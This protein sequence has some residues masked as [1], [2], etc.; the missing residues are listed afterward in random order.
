MAATLASVVA[1]VSF[2]APAAQ[3]GPAPVG[4]SPPNHVILDWTPPRTPAEIAVLQAQATTS[5]ATTIKTFTTTVVD[6]ASTFT[7]TMVGKNPFVAQTNPSKTIQATLIPVV[8]KFSNGD[9]WD[10]SAIDSC[11]T[12]SALTRTQ[13]SP[14]FQAQPWSFGAKSV[15]TGQYIDAF[16][17]A[18]FYKKTKP[19]GIN[20]GYAV[21][22]ALTTHAPFVLNV[23]AADSAELYATVCGNDKLGEVNVN[24][25]DAQLQTYIV[26]TLG[27]A[28]TTTFPLFV[29]GNV[30][31]YSGTPTN[32]CILG[33]HNAILNGGNLQ[34]YGISMYDNSGDFSPGGDT[35]TMAHEVGEWMNDPVGTNPTKPWGNV[36]QVSG[37]QSNL[38]VGDP[39]SGTVITDTLNGKTY[40]LQELAFFSWF[41]HSSPSIAVNG[42]FSSNGTFTTSAA[43]C[44]PGGP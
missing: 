42:W 16:Q 28:A 30:V 18:E 36:G 29:V 1:G 20:P 21:N 8:V 5:S 4:K 23:P 12:Q 25:L 6:G 19:T 38:E 34:T 26:G 3:A 32:C 33:Y 14:I 9:S 13:N 11:D 7:Y 24:Y 44:P 35:A 40:H 37:C 43:P 27:S 39:L 17:R 31:E 22:L 10:P 15:G 41:Y 2:A